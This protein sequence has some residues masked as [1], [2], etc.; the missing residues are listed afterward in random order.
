MSV[1]GTRRRADCMMINTRRSRNRAWRQ[2]RSLSLRHVSS[3][4]CRR[5]RH[6][7][8]RLNQIERELV[9]VG[10]MMMRIVTRWRRR[11]WPHSLWWRRKDL[12]L[13]RSFDFFV[14][15]RCGGVSS[16]E[17]IHDR[18][19]ESDWGFGLCVRRCLFC[20]GFWISSAKLAF[21]FGLRIRRCFGLRGPIF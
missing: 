1:I 6:Y 10:V 20:F 8:G 4:G 13:S 14:V 21:V 19:G 9:G 18:Q 12:R 2:H 5:C 15:V 16:A 3:F 17:E 7:W 11:R